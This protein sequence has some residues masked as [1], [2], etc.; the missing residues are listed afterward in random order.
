MNTYNPK[1]EESTA[2]WS[3]DVPGKSESISH[4]PKV[5]KRNGIVVSRLRLFSPK[6]ESSSV[7]KAASSQWS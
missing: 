3:Q 4:A 7:Q 2:V 6:V 1:K 5:K